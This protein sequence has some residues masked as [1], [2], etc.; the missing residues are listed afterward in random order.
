MKLGR[1][2]FALM[3]YLLFFN[4][5]KIDREYSK[6]LLF[7]RDY[8]EGLLEDR[9]KNLDK[10]KDS[11]DLMNIWL[12]DEYYKDDKKAIIDEIILMFLAGSFTLKTTNTNMI[13]YLT[14][15]PEVKAKLV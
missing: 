13:S 7:I 9:R 2:I 15:N 6:N 12:T 5:S 14:I 10:F 4:Y 3:P 8:C 11:N 1:P